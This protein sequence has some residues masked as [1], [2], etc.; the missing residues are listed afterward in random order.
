MS[1]IMFD[2]NEPVFAVDLTKGELAR[3]VEEIE[4]DTVAPT[5]PRRLPEP[6]ERPIRWMALI[7]DEAE[8]PLLLPI[9]PTRDVCLLDAL[10]RLLRIA[11]L[12]GERISS[13][14]INYGEELER[15][16]AFERRLPAWAYEGIEARRAS[17]LPEPL[18]TVLGPL[19]K[20]SARS[21]R[22]RSSRGRRSR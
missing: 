4:E 7:Y 18:R 16:L 5:A 20:P 2:P 14:A 21:S 19:T 3:C 13:V 9:E 22:R 6:P 10:A 8:D 12:S 1:K 11:V 15:T 17:H